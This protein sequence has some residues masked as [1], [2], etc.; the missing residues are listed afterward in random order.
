MPVLANVVQLKDE[1]RST[2][3]ELRSIERVL[4]EKSSHIDD[5]MIS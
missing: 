5:W 2:N 4:S 1:I 3:G